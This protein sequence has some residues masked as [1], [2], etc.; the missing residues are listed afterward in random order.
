MKLEKLIIGSF[1]SFVESGTA[2]GTAPNNG[3]VS[4]TQFPD[5]ANNAAAWQ[6]MGCVLDSMLE[7]KVETDT[8]LCPNPAG[9]YRIEEDENVQQDMLKMT[10]KAYSPLIHRLEWGL[11]AAIVDGTAQTPFAQHDRYILGWLNFQQRAQDGQDRIIAA[12]WGK[13]RLDGNVANTSKTKLPKVKFQ[14]ITSP[15]QT[16]LPNDILA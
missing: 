9:G 14:V 15:I 7:T 12:L 6:S 8:F 1:A 11:S 13:L 16:L 10:L 4:I 5:Q 2:Y 3:V